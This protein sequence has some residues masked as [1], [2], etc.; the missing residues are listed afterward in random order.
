ME[1]ALV[2]AAGSPREGDGDGDR[3]RGLE[4]GTQERV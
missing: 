3:E 2:S 4:Q 1:R